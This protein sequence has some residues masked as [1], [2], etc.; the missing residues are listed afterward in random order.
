M[1]TLFDF[2]THVKTVEYILAIAFIGG[3]LVYWEMLKPKPFSTLAENSRQDL[4]MVRQKGYRNM[5]RTAGKIA[6]AP[7]IGLAYIALLPLSFFAALAVAVAQAVAR[8]LAPSASFGWRPAESYLA[9]KKKRAAREKGETRE[10][11]ETEAEKD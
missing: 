1:N 8:V 5:A 10:T 4:G 11:K 9:G 3:Y 7:F 2:I 6:A